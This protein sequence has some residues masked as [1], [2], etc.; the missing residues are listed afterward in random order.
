[1]LLGDIGLVKDNGLFVFLEELL[2]RTPNLV[3][4]YVLGNHET[5]Q[6]TLESA[7][8]TMLAFAGKMAYRYGERLIIL[9]RTR[10]DINSTMTILGCTLWT[11]VANEHASE[12][13]T[14]LTDFNTSR[15]IRD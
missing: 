4:F 11:E 9:H 12:V 5:Y 15:G 13:C 7:H 3:I 6:I 8:N 14:I 1:M 2:K 10:H